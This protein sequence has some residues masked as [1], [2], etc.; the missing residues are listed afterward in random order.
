MALAR[1]IRQMDAATAASGDRLMRAATQVINLLWVVALTSS[2]QAY[3]MS[4]ARVTQIPERSV[5]IPLPG[6]V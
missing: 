1:S 3:I 6:K 5:C 2:P 4:P